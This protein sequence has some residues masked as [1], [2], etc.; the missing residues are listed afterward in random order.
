MCGRLRH[1]LMHEVSSLSCSNL[2]HLADDSEIRGTVVIH[3]EQMSVPNT[4]G[5]GAEDF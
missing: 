4:S 5:M 3:I 2:I 1:V